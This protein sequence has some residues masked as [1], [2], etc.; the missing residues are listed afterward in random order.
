MIEK[1]QKELTNRKEEK[2]VL[3]NQLNQQL[4]VLESMKKK[5]QQ[6][7]GA[8]LQLSYL[9]QDLQEQQSGPEWAEKTTTEEK[10][11]GKKE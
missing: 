3:E 6:L 1:L 5:S 10:T 4:D 11:D 9:I 7:D 2:L 8:I